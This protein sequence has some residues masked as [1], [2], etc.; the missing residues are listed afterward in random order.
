LDPAHYSV[1]VA[2]IAA[3]QYPQSQPRQTSQFG[4]NSHNRVMR[5]YNILSIILTPLAKI[6]IHRYSSLE[7][8]KIL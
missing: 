8:K 3:L 2:S 4:E 5:P 7:I 6:A 1:P